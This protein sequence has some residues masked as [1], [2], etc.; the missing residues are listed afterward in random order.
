MKGSPNPLPYS[1]VIATEEQP[2]ELQGALQS[3]ASQSRRPV[4]VIVV[5]ASPDTESRD[6][7]AEFNRRLPALW[8]CADRHSAARQRNQ[9]A[10]LVEDPLIAFVD[11]DVIL[12]AGTMD[13][14]AKVFEDDQGGEPAAWQHASTDCS[15]R[16][17][18][19]CCDVTTACNRA[20]NIV[21]T[22]RAFS[23]P[24]STVCPP[25]PR[26]TRIS[27][28]LIGSIQPAPC[29]GRNFSVGSNSLNLRNAARSKTSISRRVPPAPI[30]FAF[31]NTR[32]TPTSR[33]SAA[34]YV[35]VML[36]RG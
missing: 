32:S 13:A 12:P 34:T 17:P 1:I 8:L 4:R 9:G 33:R 22:E 23:V 18:A 26:Q 7:C 36:W 10:S 5:D 21:T 30:S 35:I 11:D 20:S 16:L 6:I 31:A 29:T 14:L 2:T 25:I 27:F 19:D 24:R 15:A 3:I 28:R